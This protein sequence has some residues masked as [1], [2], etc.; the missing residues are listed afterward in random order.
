[1]YLGRFL[2]VARVAPADDT[3]RHIH[4]AAAIFSEAHKTLQSVQSF[5]LFESKLRLVFA[6]AFCRPLDKFVES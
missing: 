6:L 2:D 4:A 3:I 5:H 1:M